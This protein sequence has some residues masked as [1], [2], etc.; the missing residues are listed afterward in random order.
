MAL[1]FAV[2]NPGHLRHQAFR[3]RRGSEL[4]QSAALAFDDVQVD[5]PLDAA[6]LA[7][8]VAYWKA[9]ESQGRDRG[10]GATH[11]A[12]ERHCSARS[13]DSRCHLAELSK[14]VPPWCLVSLS[15]PHAGGR[16]A[17]YDVL[18]GKAIHQLPAQF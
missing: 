15:I 9:A 13:F 18:A 8:R 6:V 12:S 4:D 14:K 17:L 3:A 16:K 2:A 5:L 7:K 11:A 1:R 10:G